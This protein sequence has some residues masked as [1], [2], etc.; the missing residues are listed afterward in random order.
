MV[1]R[2]HRHTYPTI[3]GTL[4]VIRRK[5]SGLVPLTSLFRQWLTT[6]ARHRRFV[7]KEYQRQLF[8]L[9]ERR[10]RIT[11][12]RFGQTQLINLRFIPFSR[13]APTIT[14]F[15]EI[16]GLPGGNSG[17]HLFVR[18]RVRKYHTF[19]FCPSNI[20]YRCILLRH[21]LFLRGRNIMVH[22]IG[23]F[24][25]FRLPSVRRHKGQHVF[26]VHVRNTTKRRV[27]VRCFSLFMRGN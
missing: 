2:V 7:W 12:R 26:H 11:S 15:V 19:Q 4:R 24:T 6:R 5:G 21:L 9:R 22:L 20:F 16:V 25:N 14:F 18:Q 13:R 8:V 1:Q 17:L 10:S 27:R 23:V 3:S